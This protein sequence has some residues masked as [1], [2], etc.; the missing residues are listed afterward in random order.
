MKRLALV[1]ALAAPAALAEEPPAE[2]IEW[3]TPEEL[4]EAIDAG[5]GLIIVDVRSEASYKKGHIP[6]AINIPYEVIKANQNIGIKPDDMIVLYCDC[7]HG[8]IALSAARI[9]KERGYKNLWV[10]LGTTRDYPGELE[11][12]PEEWQ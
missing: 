4:K 8:G 7:G 9:L 10:M 6:G 12:V 5:A 1:L 11:K 3:V 2:G